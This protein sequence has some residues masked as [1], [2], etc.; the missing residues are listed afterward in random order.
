MYISKEILRPILLSTLDIVY[1][2]LTEILIRHRVI[3]PYA[4]VSWNHSSSC[5]AKRNCSRKMKL[6]FQNRHNK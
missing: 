6:N 5:H 4:S 1:Q 2:K 3:Y